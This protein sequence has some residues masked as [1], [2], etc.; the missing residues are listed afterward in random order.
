[1]NR[2]RLYMAMRVDV[3]ALGSV[4]AAS[5]SRWPVTCKAVLRPIY[6]YK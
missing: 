4:N 6:A 5:T 1:M 3:D 2:M